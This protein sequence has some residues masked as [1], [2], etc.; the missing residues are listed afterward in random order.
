ML[1]VVTI[2]VLGAWAFMAFAPDMVVVVMGRI[3][4]GWHLVV[5]K[6]SEA[7]PPWANRSL[8]NYVRNYKA[9]YSPLRM[10]NYNVVSM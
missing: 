3:R 9:R 5:I 6:L 1:M 4:L 2:S 10:S 7:K 8:L